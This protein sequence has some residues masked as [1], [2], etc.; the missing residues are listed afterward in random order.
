M[1][2]YIEYNMA[3]HCMQL[4]NSLGGGGD[5]RFGNIVVGKIVSI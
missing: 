5:H 1:V 3:E 4:C 2:E